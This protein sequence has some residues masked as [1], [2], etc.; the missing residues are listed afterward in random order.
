MISIYSLYEGA[1][2]HTACENNR[3]AVDLRLFP[4]KGMTVPPQQFFKTDIMHE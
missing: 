3:V 2:Y 1:N 4:A